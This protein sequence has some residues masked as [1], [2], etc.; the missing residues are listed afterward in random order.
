[1]TKVKKSPFKSW[2]TL[3]TAQQKRTLARLTKMSLV[4]LSQ[5]AGG[6]NLRPLTARR[7][8]IATERMA[9][10]TDLPA[11][12]RSS[13]CVACSICEFAQRCEK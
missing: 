8:A 1:M 7:I 6:R 10:L 13:L 2:W 12:R 5:I 3:A 11:V 4:Q 9:N